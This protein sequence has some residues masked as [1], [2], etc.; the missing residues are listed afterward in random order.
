MMTS[1]SR[2]FGE[3]IGRVPRLFICPDFVVAF[4]PDIG[5]IIPAMFQIGVEWMLIDIVML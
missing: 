4:L 3:V 2:G 5:T 1:L